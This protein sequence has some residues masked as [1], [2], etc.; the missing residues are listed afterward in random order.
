MSVRERDWRGFFRRV[1][2]Q[3]RPVVEAASRFVVRGTSMVRC[4]GMS[5]ALAYNMLHFGR[6]LIG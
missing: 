2:R 1:A 3:E 4:V 5:S 6:E